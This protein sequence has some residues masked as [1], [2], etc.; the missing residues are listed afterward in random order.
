MH[1]QF[2]FFENKYYDLILIEYIDLS[3]NLCITKINKLT[4]FIVEDIL[5]YDL[6]K[7]RAEVIYSWLKVADYLRQRKDH[8][9][10]LAIYSAINHYT[11]TGL[12]L[13]KKEMKSK[14]KLLFYNIGDYCK[15]DANYKIFREE[16]HNCAKN[17]EF[18]LPFL[19]LL[20][21][22]IYFFNEN[23][24]IIWINCVKVKSF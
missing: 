18:F 14:V 8:N 21:K 23:Y 3:F 1:E 20:L 24:L 10:C 22:D 17:K 4:T 2:L 7:V 19:G 13:T 12:D 15:I 5:S 11:I 16:I 9:D 6:P